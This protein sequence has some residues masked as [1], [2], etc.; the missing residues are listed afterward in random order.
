MRCRNS[1][2][3]W[4]AA[5]TCRKIGRTTRCAEKKLCP[6][7]RAVSHETADRLGTD[8]SGFGQRSLRSGLDIRRVLRSRRQVPRWSGATPTDVRGR[9]SRELPRL[10]AETSNPAFGAEKEQKR[11]W[12]QEVSA[13]G[14]SPSFL[15]GPKLGEILS[16]VPGAV[17][18]AVSHQGTRQ[19]H[20]GWGGT[21]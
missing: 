12:S 20:G 10:G 6:R 17:V 1:N 14:A 21:T 3:C 7:R 2:V 4:A 19:G 18:A 5:C 11:R 16:G 8:R 13:V 9:S 15:R